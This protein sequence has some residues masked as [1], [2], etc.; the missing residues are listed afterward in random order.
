MSEPRARFELEVSHA[1]AIAEAVQ[2]V[3][4]VAE[5]DGG[6]FGSVSLYFPGERITG[7]RQPNPRDD[8]HLQIN[9]RVDISAAPDLYALAEDIRSAARG[10]CPE[11]QRIDVEFSDAVDGLSAAPSKE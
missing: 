1:R 8:R 7:M 6:S 10:A 3:R 11:L 4:G 2:Q 9:I 5:L